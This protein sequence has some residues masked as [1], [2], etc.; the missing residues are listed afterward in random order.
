VTDEGAALSHAAI[1]ARE[2]G[3]PAV[4]GWNNA[5]TH[6]HTSDR[7]RVKGRQGVVDVLES[8]GLYQANRRK[9]FDKLGNLTGGLLE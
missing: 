8:A 9:C 3:I 5:T 2:L 1:V 7:V 6:S 4:A